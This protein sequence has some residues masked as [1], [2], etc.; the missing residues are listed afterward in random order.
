MSVSER[1][2]ERYYFAIA[3]A[4]FGIGLLPSFFVFWW[5]SRVTGDLADQFT[6]ISGAHVGN[7]ERDV[8]AHLG[9]P[10]AVLRPSDSLAIPGYSP[11]PTLKVSNRTSIYKLGRYLLYVFYGND[12]QVEATYITERKR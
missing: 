10:S 7:V 6:L 2:K 8:L 4:A 5:A 12:A 3:I 11:V 1:A 9:P